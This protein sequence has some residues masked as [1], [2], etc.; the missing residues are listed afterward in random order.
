MP[1]LSGG[2]PAATEPEFI[3]M[4]MHLPRWQMD[5]LAEMAQRHGIS[6]GQLLRRWIARL[7]REGTAPRP[8]V[9]AN[10]LL[11]TAK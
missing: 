2:L 10:R 5:V 11:N 4:S 7:V 8:E 6:I 9:A 3:E 1:E